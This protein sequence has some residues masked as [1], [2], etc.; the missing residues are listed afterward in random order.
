MKR[1][2]RQSMKTTILYFLGV[3]TLIFISCSKEEIVNDTNNTASKSIN[4]GIKHETESRTLESSPNQYFVL[5]HENGTERLFLKASVAEGIDSDTENH[6]SRGALVTA[7]NSINQFGVM[8]YKEGAEIPWFN[9]TATQTINNGQTIWATTGTHYWPNEGQTLDF[10]S[11]YP[12]TSTTINVGSNKALTANYTIPTIVTNQNDAMVAI[13]EG[14]IDNYY[15]SVGISFKHLCTAI[16]FK[17]AEN[18]AA[19]GK[20]T[21]ITISGVKGGTVSYTYNRNS[22]SPS[23]TVTSYSSATTSYELNFDKSSTDTDKDITTDNNI[24]LLAPQTL[25]AEAKILITFEGKDYEASISG[26]WPI[27]QTVTYTIDITPNYTLDF[28]EFT[29]TLDAHYIITTIK[30]R[31]DVNW[32]MS[33]PTEAQSWAYLSKEKTNTSMTNTENKVNEITANQKAGMWSYVEKCNKASISGTVKKEGTV[34]N[35]MVYMLLRENPATSN[36]SVNVELKKSGETSAKKQEFIQLGYK[37]YNGV[38]MER[39]ED[40]TSPYGFAV[41]H[42]NVTY[43]YKSGSGIW[44]WLISSIVNGW[45]GFLTFT[46]KNMTIDLTTNVSGMINAN[47]GLSNTSNSLGATLNTNQSY[48]IEQGWYTTDANITIDETKT[49]MQ[50]CL[51]KNSYGDFTG[52]NDDNETELTTSKIKWYL[53]A[54]NEMLKVNEQDTNPANSYSGS[55]WS[56]TAINDNTNAY[57]WSF[58]ASQGTSKNRKQ[59]L[60]IRCARTITQ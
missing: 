18:M 34:E 12:S 23:W 22:Q 14:V 59:E 9:E 8:A 27:G 58:G 35:V 44:A 55:Y 13:N 24:F 17:F 16:R 2:Y 48:L 50:Y 5:Q 51:S 28:T 54:I 15:Q 41:T 56:S 4:F 6:I 31:T 60:K 19:E 53:P 39:I 7:G 43:K 45:T 37:L 36:R 47:S 32:T 49:A 1:L 3:C 46:P 42:K 21:Q 40:A 38:A 20:V 29:E 25:P 26:E 10:Y 57:S 30:F 33:I 11:Y 52:N